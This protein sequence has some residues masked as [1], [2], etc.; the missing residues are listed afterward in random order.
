MADLIT[1]PDYKA[2]LGV[3]P[4]DDRN[5]TQIEALIPAVT[6][7]IRTFTGR[8]FEVAAAPATSRSFQHDGAEILD[9]DDCTGIVSLSTDTGV[10]GNSYD[11]TTDEWTAMPQ[12]DSDVFYYVLIHG[13]PHFG[14]S[15]EMGF[16]RNLDQYEFRGR[17]PL[18]TVTATWGWPAIPDDVKLAAALTVQA[19]MSSGTAGRGGEDLTSEAIEGWARSWGGRSGEMVALAIPNKARDILAGYQRIFV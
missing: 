17:S 18:I 7:A 16:E 6:R 10:P 9:I 1:L 19:I 15:P 11:L 2:L 13:G 4:T 8:N 5:D 14:I 3:Q 12:D